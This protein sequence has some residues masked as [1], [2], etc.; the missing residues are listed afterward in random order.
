MAPSVTFRGISLSS[1]F[2]PTSEKSALSLDW[3]LSS[4]TTGSSSIASGVLCLPCANASICSMNVQLLVSPSLPFDLVLG[5]DWHLFCRDAMPDATFFLSRPLPP[6]PP[7]DEMDV[8]V[9]PETC[10][11][12]DLPPASTCTCNNQGTCPSTSTAVHACMAPPATISLNILRDIFTARH[13]THSRISVFYSDLPT[14][15]RALELHAIPHYEM[16]LIQCRHALIHHLATGACVDHQ[17]DVLATARPDRSACHALAQD[18]KNAAAMSEAVLTLILEADHKKMATENLCHVASSLNIT[19]VGSRNLR[20][21]LKNAIRQNLVTVASAVADSR[22]SASVADFFSSFES[23]RKPVLLSIAALHQVQLPD[24]PGMED[25]RKAISEHILSGH[26]TQFSAPRC[27]LTAVP[28]PDCLDVC[29]EW[30]QNAIDPDI[31]VH[32]LKAIN[33]N[34]VS[35]K[36]MWRILRILNVDFDESEPIKELRKK[37]RL[38]I[39]ALR[40]GKHVERERQAEIELQTRYK[41]EVQKVRE[42]WPQ[43]VPQSLKDKII[44]LFRERTSS[45]A[46]TNFT[47]AS[48]A[49]AVPLHSH[50]SMSLNDFDLQLLKRPDLNCNEDI[51]LDQYK[52]LHPDC[53]PPP[54]SYDEGPL[55]DLLLDPDGVSYSTDSGSPILSLC[56]VCNS[57]LKNNKIPPLS[58][59]NKTF[60]GPVPEEL[61]NLTV[62]EEAMIA[63]CRSKCWIIQLREEK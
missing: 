43:L 52:W 48:C 18:F 42:S 60:L 16:T 63:L 44:A 1:S 38:Y 34:K 15:H 54:M 58:L 11:P 40:K 41:E 7:N 32:I 4:G 25:I 56:S 50:C 53:V 46:L 35:P 23:H 31:Q 62:I 27:P 28:Q 36:T 12:H 2:D 29:N 47:C 3:I 33:R 55:K 51:I 24:K 5:R 45:E 39:T 22:S 57:S 10:A 17:S 21:K 9:D 8:D 59:A 30:R 37:L 20:F 14:I 61:K 26:C 19:T 13:S 49:E 6:S